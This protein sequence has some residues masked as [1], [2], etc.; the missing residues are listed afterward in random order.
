[1]SFIEKDVPVF[2][3]FI[4]L[5]LMTIDLHWYLQA[6]SSYRSVWMKVVDRQ[7]TLVILFVLGPCY[8]SI[9]VRYNSHG[10]EAC[11]E[12]IP[13]FAYAS[14]RA[15]ACNDFEKAIWHRHG[16]FASCP[17][18]LLTCSNGSC[19]LSR[20]HFRRRI[21]TVWTVSFISLTVNNLLLSTCSFDCYKK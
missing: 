19:F 7:Y 5:A 21:I 9:N 14:L 18:K 6:V 20:V 11:S 15:N 17:R 2:S 8:R 16:L 1:M 10:N 3:E 13:N 12:P 4:V